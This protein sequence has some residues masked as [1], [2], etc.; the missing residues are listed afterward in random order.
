MKKMIRNTKIF[1]TD[2]LNVREIVR[3]AIAADKK[4]YNRTFQQVRGVIYICPDKWPMYAVQIEAL[5]H[6]VVDYHVMRKGDRPT[7]SILFTLLSRRELLKQI[8]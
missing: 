2:I 4:Q 7:P 6:Y 1:F 5:Q 8:K 3:S